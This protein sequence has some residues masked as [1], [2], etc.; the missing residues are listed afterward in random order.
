MYVLCRRDVDNATLTCYHELKTEKLNASDLW[1]ETSLED[2]TLLWRKQNYR[3]HRAI[4]KYD[5]IC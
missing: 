4:V 1:L 5:Y 3:G 2:D